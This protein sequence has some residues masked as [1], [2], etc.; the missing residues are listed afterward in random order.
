MNIKLIS[1]VHLEHGTD[2]NV[3]I[4]KTPTDVLIVA[5][6][7]TVGPANT[8]RALKELSNHARHIVYTPGNHEYYGYTIQ[9]FNQQLRTLLAN[10]PNIHF[11]YNEYVTIDGTHF[12]GTPLWTNFRYNHMAM[13]AARVMISDFKYIKN[14][15]P[16]QSAIEFYNSVQ[17][18]KYAQETLKGRKVIVTHFLPATECIA[19]QYANENLLNNYFCNDL[20]EYIEFLEDTT[21]VFGHTHA[22]INTKLFSTPLISNPYGYPGEHTD[23]YAPVTVC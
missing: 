20:A 9:E 22:P 5:G 19:P 8:Y 12:I 2:I 11:L 3:V 7:L 10:E 16:E 14:F 15:T 23:N 18:I 1:D 21:W 4:P 17:F 6:D 13:L